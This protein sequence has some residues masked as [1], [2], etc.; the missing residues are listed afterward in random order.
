MKKW[1]ADRL[2]SVTAIIVSLGTL[3]TIVFQTNLIRKQ[4]Y[5]SVLPYL[6][7]WPRVQPNSFK[8][9][10]MNNGI[11]PAFIE[12]VR[13]HYNDSI[14]EGDPR[15]FTQGVIRKQEDIEFYYSTLKKGRLLPA[16]E[17]IEL[18]G[19][20][21]DSVNTLKLYRWFGGDKVDLEV[22]YKS[23]YDETWSARGIGT[24][25]MELN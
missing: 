24:E 5:A 6:E 4:Q 7:I 19:I 11:G 22:V 16:G 21:D 20:E 15:A 13:I 2:L 8:L 10:L 1:S 9:L 23:V 14:F 18:I 12:G 3:F 17:I 25:P